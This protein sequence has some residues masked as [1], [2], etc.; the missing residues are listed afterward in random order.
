MVDNKHERLMNKLRVQ[1]QHTRLKQPAGL[2]FFLPKNTRE[3]KG[4]E[5]DQKKRLE[6]TGAFCTAPS[7]ACMIFPVECCTAHR[8]MTPAMAPAPFSDGNPDVG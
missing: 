8:A 7:S 3:T 4:E 6:M 2:A 1:R 5:E